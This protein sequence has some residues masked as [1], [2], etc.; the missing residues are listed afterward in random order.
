M[1]LAEGLGQA[2][3]VGEAALAGLVHRVDSCGEVRRW[4]FSCAS[5]WLQ[6]TLGMRVGRADE[7]TTLARQLARLAETAKRFRSGG[8]S[9]G[10]AATICE[11]VS[12][13]DDRDA[14]LG[15]RILL[16]LAD[17][18]GSASQVSTAGEHI[19]E[20][21]ADRGG[22]EKP[23]EDSRR[24]FKRSWI[25]RSKS[26]GG[27][28]WVKGWL[29]SEDTA[30]FDELVDPLAKPCG[31]AD[32]RDHAQRTADALFTLLT[33]GH[34]RATVTVIIDLDLFY[35]G[36]GSARLLGA[37]GASRPSGPGSWRCPRGCRR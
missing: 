10:Y 32:D 3:D 13:L 25:Q 9:Y 8:L 20:A 21:I 37:V 11:A 29:D 12:S 28:S 27:G 31:A 36:S 33:Q 14:E 24:G 26:L 19:T 7:R 23:P 17:A 5:V 18:G 35:G 30:I 6:R 4:G 16:E 34:E 2:L 22:R 15:E 1:E